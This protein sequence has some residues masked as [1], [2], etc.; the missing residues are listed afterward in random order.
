[1]EILRE[2]LIES[3][4]FLN[5]SEV[6]TQIVADTL[7]LLGS[8]LLSFVGYLFVKFLIKRIIKHT[9]TNNKNDLVK[10][11]LESTVIPRVLRL[12][13]L[14][15]L[16]QIISYLPTYY[17]ITEKF[18]LILFAYFILKVVLG[19]LDF[20]NALYTTYNKQASSKPIKGILTAIKFVIVIV[21]VI[22]VISSLIGESPVVILTGLGAMSAVLMLIFKDSIL[23]L[24]A[25][26]QMSVHD[27][28]RIGDWI[29]MPNY[30]AD[31][32]VMDVTLTF[33]R[34]QNWDNTTVTIPAYKLISESFTNWRSVFEQ[35]GRR[36]KRAVH[37]D[38]KS[39]KILDDALYEKLLKVDFVRP[40]LQTRKQEIDTYNQTNQIDTSVL[41][42]GR[43]L[44]NLGVYRVY[45][46]E[47][48]KNNPNIH[49]NMWRLV[50]QLE[51]NNRGI[52]LEIY[53]FSNKTS[54]ADY[55]GVMADIFDHIYATISY[56]ELKI[57]QE[58]SGDD[59]N[60]GFN[61]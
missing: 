14:I 9:L 25:G 41:L 40:Y 4:G 43:R 11:L 38:A 22:V 51:N 39:V 13:P 55:E 59:I 60:A 5:Q 37:I 18:I 54:W 29:E 31:G 45:L 57:F 27:L 17:V 56:F 10:I 58:P 16:I 50:R 61:R 32:H 46:T 44:T 33:I 15:I 36:I 20:I 2:Q 35:G 3:L 7:I 21:V 48:L 52:P 19:M 26:F 53:T 49:E 28:V 47:Y 23:G 34:I 12:I 1:M 6:T 30:G 42:N 24:V 8:L